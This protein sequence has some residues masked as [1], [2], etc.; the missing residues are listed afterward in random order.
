MKSSL[1]LA[2]L[3]S[4]SAASAQGVAA[5]P[6]VSSENTVERNHCF[7]AEVES[8]EKLLRVE[9]KR[10][11]GVLR[12]RDEEDPMFQLAKA[13]MASQVKW[14]EFREA[15]CTFRSR[16]YGRGTGAPAEGMWCEIEHG[17]IRLE[18]MKGIR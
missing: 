3:L 10:V 7:A 14:R 18:Y 9:L 1:V 8:L 15:E 11:E 4:S 6:C 2:L 12:Q 17:R 5:M 16:T 13:F